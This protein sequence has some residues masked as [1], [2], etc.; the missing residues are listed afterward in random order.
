MNVA[1]R[2]GLRALQRTRVDV[3]A[4]VSDWRRRFGFDFPFLWVQI[5]PWGGHEAQNS[6][7][8]LPEIRSA[9]G[10]VQ[11]LPLTAVAS[12]VD[13]GSNASAR[14]WDTGDEH[15][16]DPWGNVHFR[17]KASLGPRIAACALHV[18]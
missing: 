12:A 4:M 16:V 11:Q 7:F 1:V 17:D 3:Q 15:G 5:S 8:R 6:S 14:G 2:V 13:L 18:V 10:A 9:Q